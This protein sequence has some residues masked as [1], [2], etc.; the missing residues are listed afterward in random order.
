MGR[1]APVGAMGPGGGFEDGPGAGWPK[2]PSGALVWFHVPGESSLGA[3]DEVIQRLAAV[4]PDL[5]MLVTTATVP[6]QRLRAPT[7]YTTAPPERR[8]EI[9]RFLG[10]WRPDAAIWLRG[11]LHPLLV[12]EVQARGVPMLLADASAP[13]FDAAQ[14]RWR[15][16]RTRA[17]LRGMARILAVDAAAI[18]APRAIGAPADRVE[19]RGPLGE[20]AVPL[21]YSE[22]DRADM[23]ETLATRPV[24][25]AMHVPLS[26]VE[27]VLGAHR[28]AQR[29]AHRLLLCLVPADPDEA[30]TLAVAVFAAGFTLA[31]RSREGEPDGAVEVFLADDGDE[32]GLW[33]RIAPICFMGG[34]LSGTPGRNPHEAAALGCAIVHGPRP[35]GHAE[36]YARLDRAGAAVALATEDELGTAVGDLLA[37]DRVAALAHAAWDVTTAGAEVT[38]RLVALIREALGDTDDGAKD[39]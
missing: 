16:G 1:A 17:L 38:D 8:T 26:E 5:R 36:A 32:A 2:R 13:G 25:A 14:G 7:Y 12:A 18:A 9:L 20:A 33:Y 39:A 35:R 23:A 6:A 30:E 19:H 4:R 24:W 27:T 31:R 34:T 3:V 11:H 28:A 37:P 15:R 21:N 22:E 29:R 10:H